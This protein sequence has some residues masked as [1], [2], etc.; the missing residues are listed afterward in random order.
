MQLKRM[1]ERTLMSLLMAGEGL[2]YDGVLFG[3]D[4]VPHVASAVKGWGAANAE[5]ET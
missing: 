1:P 2:G 3:L 5:K 4:G